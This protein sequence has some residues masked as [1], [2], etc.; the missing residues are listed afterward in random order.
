MNTKITY[1]YRDA[2]NYKNWNEVII[3]G[4]ITTEQITPYLLD[5]RCFIANETG[6]KDMHFTPTNSDDHNWHEI[7]SLEPTKDLPTTSLTANT[8]LKNL[9]KMKQKH[10][11]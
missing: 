2:G 9:K 1:L 6:L 10:L 7:E 8:L 4:Q 5:G 11:L 3:A